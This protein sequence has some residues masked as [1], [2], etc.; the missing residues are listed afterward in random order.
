LFGYDNFDPQL[1]SGLGK[2]TAQHEHEARL[3][4]GGESMLGRILISSLWIT[5]SMSPSSTA[6][7]EQLLAENKQRCDTVSSCFLAIRNQQQ[8]YKALAAVESQ[9]YER[10]EAKTLDEEQ[11]DELNLILDEADLYCSEEN[12]KDAKSKIKSVIEIVLSSSR[13]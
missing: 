7:G 10:V 12:V 4:R 2:R 9:L 11:I 5:L 13:E 1:S 8:C 3:P 6:Q